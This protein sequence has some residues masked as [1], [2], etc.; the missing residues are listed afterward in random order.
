M[1]PFAL[2]DPVTAARFL[3]VKPDTLRHWRRPKYKGA[4]KIP[5]VRLGKQV[6]YRVADLEAIAGCP[7]TKP[8]SVNGEA[9]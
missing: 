5:F 1:S 3:A 6:R 9:K 8:G 4:P 7:F 2:V